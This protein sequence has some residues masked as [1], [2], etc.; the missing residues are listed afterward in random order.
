MYV[1]TDADRQKVKQ[2]LEEA[3]K[4]TMRKKDEESHIR[5]ILNTLKQDHDIQP[6]IARKVISA[7]L[8]GNIPE[9]REEN[10]AFADLCEIAD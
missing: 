9:V 4:A 6:K 2:Y 5:D 8:K 7:M 10:D 3:S 1:A